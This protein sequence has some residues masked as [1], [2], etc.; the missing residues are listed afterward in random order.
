MPVGVALPQLQTLYL[1][2]PNK[3][4]KLGVGLSAL[5]ELCLQY[6]KQQL[7]EQILSSVGHQLIKLS[8]LML[9][10]LFLDRVFCFCPKLEVFLVSGLPD[11][12]IGL[13][14]ALRPCSLS[15]LSEFGLVV[16]KR[17]NHLMP[18][19]LLQVLRAASKLRV[20]RLKFSEH[21]EQ[22]DRV[23]GGALE[24]HSVLQNLE[25][26]FFVCE[27]D[28]ADYYFGDLRLQQNQL[29]M[30]LHALLCSIIDNCPKLYFVK[31]N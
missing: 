20:L 6:L 11:G 10:T 2:S 12:F 5:T 1:Y 14:A 30:N 9:D 3:D 25:Q 16:Q 19:H 28:R 31:S 8:V 27:L 13:E 22:L 24:E 29:E 15:C 23:T 17:G 26:L 7:L 18:G 21:D 4:F